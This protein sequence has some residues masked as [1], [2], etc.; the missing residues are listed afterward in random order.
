LPGECLSTSYQL[1]YG[2]AQVDLQKNAFDHCNQ[3]GGEFTRVLVVDDLMA[4]GGTLAAACELINNSKIAQV[5]NAFLIMELGF[6][7]GRSKLPQNVL[8]TSLINYQD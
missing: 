5:T 1:E 7:N 6:L 4:T 2:S 8:V 3:N